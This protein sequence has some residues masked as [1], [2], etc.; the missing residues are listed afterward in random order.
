M[1]CNSGFDEH[2]SSKVEAFL[3]PLRLYVVRDYDLA[4]TGLDEQSSALAASHQWPHVNSCAV[5][6]DPASCCE[7]HTIGFCMCSQLESL[8][9]VLEA[10]ISIKDACWQTIKSRDEHPSISDCNSANFGAGVLAPASNSAGHLQEPLI[11]MGRC[12]RGFEIVQMFYREGN[13]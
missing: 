13:V 5:K 6:T 11:P 3:P 1:N 9:S 4:D 10:G 12:F 7:C 2:C 8:I